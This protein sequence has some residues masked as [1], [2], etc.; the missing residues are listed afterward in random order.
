ME[1]VRGVVV[2]LA[3]AS[4]C[5]FQH[6]ALGQ[7][8]DAALVDGSDVQVDAAIDAELDAR[9]LVCPGSYALTIANTKS[10]YRVI[11]AT[12]AF[13]TQHQDCNN[14]QTGDTHLASIESASEA[15]D[16]QTALGASAATNYYVGAAQ[17]PSQQ[18]TTD[19]WF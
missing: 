2:V 8:I 5:G 9:V 19:G 11:T 10:R 6:G 18:L 12:A 17:K 16:L 1:V 15:S 3:C 14:D 4:G 7:P 13:A